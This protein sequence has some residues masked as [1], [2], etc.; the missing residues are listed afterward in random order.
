M[1]ETTYKKLSE[2]TFQDLY[3]AEADDNPYPALTAAFREIYDRVRGFRFSWTKPSMVS[4]RMT[5][6]HS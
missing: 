5:H 3:I 4:H 2:L 1:S 6:R